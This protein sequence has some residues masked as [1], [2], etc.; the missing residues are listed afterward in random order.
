MNEPYLQESLV[1]QQD[2]RAASLLVH[3]NALGASKS[4]DCEST[5]APM[6]MTMEE[7]DDEDWLAQ[8]AKPKSSKHL[9][10]EVELDDEI[11]QNHEQLDDIKPNFRSPPVG[12][13]NDP[14]MQTAEP[15]AL[16]LDAEA[17]MHPPAVESRGPPSLDSKIRLKKR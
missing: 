7:L 11:S 3:V 14:A 15:T 13:E 2:F 6:R 5:E 4:G 8:K 17:N 10:E 9:L 16:S 1:Q 12:D